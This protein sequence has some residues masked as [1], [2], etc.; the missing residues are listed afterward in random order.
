MTTPSPF[1][2]LKVS[3]NN[4]RPGVLAVFERDSAL[5]TE[6]ART[7]YG[8]VVLFWTLFFASGGVLAGVMNTE[9]YT[10]VMYN[11]MLRKVT[12]GGNGHA[13]YV[14]HSAPPSRPH[15]SARPLH[16]SIRLAPPRAPV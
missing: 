8:A 12:D 3:A 4:A 10:H 14:S 15:K 6:M 2:S 11:E 7:V 13:Q 16:G 5:V 9:E 1:V